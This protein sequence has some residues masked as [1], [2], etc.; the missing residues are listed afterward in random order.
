MYNNSGSNQLLPVSSDVSDSTENHLN[1]IL[2]YGYSRIDMLENIFSIRQS[3]S[4]HGRQRPDW[5]R[6]FHALWTKQFI[7]QSTSDLFHVL[8]LMYNATGEMVSTSKMYLSSEHSTKDQKE[9]N[10]DVEK[11]ALVRSHSVIQNQDS[12]S[13]ELLSLAYSKNQHQIKKLTLIHERGRIHHN[14]MYEHAIQCNSRGPIGYSRDLI[15]ISSD[16]EFPD[17]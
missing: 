3:K 2:P 12:D 10:P 9:I 17:L 16:E 1:S 14:V 7:P 4:L 13:D 8:Q 11:L 15:E 5:I 6:K